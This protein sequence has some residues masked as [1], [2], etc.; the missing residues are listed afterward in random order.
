MV[1][2]ELRIHAELAVQGLLAQLRHAAQVMHA[3]TSGSSDI[4]GMIMGQSE[5]PNAAKN[6]QNSFEERAQKLKFLLDKG[7]I[8][9]ERYE[10]KLEELL[11][12]I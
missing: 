6:A 3:Y 2:K 8:S 7:M 1:D 11:N 12:D 10:E 5:S 4:A 9:Q